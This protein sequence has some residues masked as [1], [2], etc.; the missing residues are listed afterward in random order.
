MTALTRSRS[1]THEKV[2]TL[3]RQIEQDINLGR[4]GA[5]FWLKQVDM[6]EQYGCTRIDLRQALDRLVEKRLV[7][8]EANRGYRVAKIE[9]DRLAEILDLRAILETAAAELIMGR[10]DEAALQAL[11]VQAHAFAAAVSGGTIEEQELTNR[12]FHATLLAHCPNRE[13]VTVVFELRSRVPLPVTR[14][15]NTQRNLERSASEHSEMIACFREGDMLRL[16]ALTQRHV[17]AVLRNG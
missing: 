7:E 10:L 15:K 8:L 16:R 2:L 17:T 11:Q 12:R 4:L 3:A 6:E 13:L 1:P 14:Q 9:Q 5:G